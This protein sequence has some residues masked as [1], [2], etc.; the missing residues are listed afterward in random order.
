M[1]LVARAVTALAVLALATPALPCGFDK[2]HTTTTSA[3]APSGAVAKTEKASGQ[4]AQ[5]AVKA[6]KAK[7]PTAQR[8][9]AN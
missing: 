2:P 5:K 4:G 9:A 6:E 1:K 7:A 8:T 3:P